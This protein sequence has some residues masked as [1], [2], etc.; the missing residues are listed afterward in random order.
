[1]YSAY[2]KHNQMSLDTPFNDDQDFWKS[3]GLTSEVDLWTGTEF[4]VP[5]LDPQGDFWICPELD[6]E[7]SG[8]GSNT[9]QGH[10]TTEQGSNTTDIFFDPELGRFVIPSPNTR[11]ATP[12]TEATLQHQ[13]TM[14]E[15]E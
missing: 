14:L 6:L 15:S 7:D 9:K 10:D 12:N 11:A 3:L 8:Q 1:M 5:E 2:N 4:T 13:I